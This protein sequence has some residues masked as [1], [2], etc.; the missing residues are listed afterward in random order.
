MGE[1]VASQVPTRQQVERL[2]SALATL[3]QIEAPTFHHFADGMYCREM[4]LP[5]GAAIVGKVHKREHFFMLVKGTLRVTTDT[6]VTTLVAPAILVGRP[7]TKRAGFALDDV[8]CVNVHR[9]FE[10]DLQAI[11]AECIEPDESALL[12]CDNKL[13]PLALENDA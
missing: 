4:H 7:G 13:K 12:D 5:A 11:E 3:P 10:T 9:T 6:G 1:V 8:V 2:Q